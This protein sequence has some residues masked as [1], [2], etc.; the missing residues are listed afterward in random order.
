VRKSGDFDAYPDTRSQ[1]YCPIEQQAAASDDAVKATQR[2][3]VKYRGSI[4]TTFFSSS[5]GG[6]TSSLEGSWGSPNQPYLVPVPDPYDAANGLNPNHDWAP[7]AYTPEG[8]TAQLGVSGLIRRMDH[9]IDAPSKRVVSVVLHRT[10][11]DATLSGS[12]VYS[13]LGLRSTWFRILQ[14]SLAAPTEAVAGSIFTLQGRVWPKPTGG[15]HLEQ[16]VGKTGDWVVIKTPALD[17]EGAFSIP[18]RSNKNIAYRIV[19]RLAFSPVEKIGVYPNLTLETAPGGGFR[20][21]MVRPVLA[22]SEVLLVRN[23]GGG[24]EIR[25]SAIV[26]ADGS[27]SFSTPV[28]QGTWKAHFAGDDDHS[29]GNSPLLDVTT[30]SRP[31]PPE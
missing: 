12:D 1:V 10:N 3:V 26:G 13:R 19:R 30:P 17:A 7:K 11:G 21:T 16:R 23:L 14:V 31:L 4:A 28:T 29:L 2:Q 22:G 24:W 27:Y 25:D 18:R 15:Y 9:N 8:L 6:H 5:S 20:G